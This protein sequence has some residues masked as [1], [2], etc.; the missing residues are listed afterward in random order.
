MIMSWIVLAAICLVGFLLRFGFLRSSTGDDWFTKWYIGQQKVAPFRLRYT[1]SAYPGFIGYPPLLFTLLGRLPENRIYI[2]GRLISPLL[3]VVMTVI[4]YGLVVWLAGQ[5]PALLPAGVMPEHF[6][7]AI[8]AL[9]ISSPLLMP[10]AARLAGIK[11]RA[12]GEFFCILQYLALGGYFV[13]GH[14]GYLLV[15]GLFCALL[16]V[17]SQMA[18]QATFFFAF[19]FAAIYVSPVPILLPIAVVAIG[20]FIPRVPFREILM[21]RIHHMR[22]YYRNLQHISPSERNHVKDVISLPRY[23]TGDFKRFLEVFLTLNS[24]LILLVAMPEGAC[25]LA[26]LA[27]AGVFEAVWAN[28]YLKFCLAISAAALAT[29]LYTSSRWGLHM[30]EAERYFNFAIPFVSLLFAWLALE[31]GDNGWMIV[32][33]ILA[34]HVGV[35]LITLYYGEY[36]TFAQGLRAALTGSAD[37][38]AELNQVVAVANQ[39]ADKYGETLVVTMPAKFSYML[40]NINKGQ[41][42]RFLYPF[43]YNERGLADMEDDFPKYWQPHANFGQFKDKYKCPVLV[44]MHGSILRQLQAQGV[45]LSR[46]TI[47]NGR[48]TALIVA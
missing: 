8:A 44:M 16:I 22:W 20:W 11:A 47:F 33:A 24:Y 46:V 37:E 28:P 6:A 4:L 15:A 41:K 39:F 9:Y 40:S 48:H 19:A 43:V 17:S 29:F 10:A 36:D 21:A 3:D 27:D 25:I 30:G 35:A 31:R 26:W 42:L 23:L 38:V 2:V 45:D 13:H 14:W 34:V 32:A 5:E 12:I 1:D 18:I 7:L